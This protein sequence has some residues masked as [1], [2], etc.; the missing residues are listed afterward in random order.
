MRTIKSISQKIYGICFE[1]DR[2]ISGC[3]HHDAALWAKVNSLRHAQTI[4]VILDYADVTNKRKLNILNA[5]GL[6]SGHQNFA[7][8]HFLRNNTPLE[9]HWHVFESP[10]SEYLDNDVFKKYIDN[11]HISMQLIDFNKIKYFD[12][13]ANVYDV[14][15]FT[16]IAEHL[17][18]SIFLQSLTLI[19]R[20]MVDDGLL[21]LTTPNLVSL[22]NRIRILF[23]NGD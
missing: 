17:D 7:I 23:G 12:N 10:S 14:V 11:L 8:V 9:I 1:V 18:Y 2:Y 4:K 20:I 3:S 5:S 15:L 13:D 19:R 6:S 22:E 21:I 16:E